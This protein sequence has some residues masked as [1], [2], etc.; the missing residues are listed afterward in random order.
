MDEQEEETRRAVRL[1]ESLTEMKGIT[2]GELDELLGAGRSYSS[3]LFTHRISPRYERILQILNVLEVEPSF[4]F[5]VL[6]PDAQDRQG[7]PPLIER[8]LARLHP[9]SA[10]ATPASAPSTTPSPVLTE[11]DLDRR[12]HAAIDAV[13]LNR[14]ATGH[15]RIRSGKGKQIGH[16]G[17]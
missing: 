14:T 6:F 11:A 13:L 4:F 12:I 15:K 17:G 16:A 8:F 2:R 10:Q 3:Q 9:S 5:R 7:Q 1:L